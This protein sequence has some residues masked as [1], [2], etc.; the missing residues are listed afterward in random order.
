MKMS[1]L[2]KTTFLIPG[3]LG[4]LAMVALALWLGR[5][6]DKPL[7]LRVPGTD[8]A[9]GSESGSGANAV[10]AGKLI[11]SDGQPANLPGAWP[12]F[13]GPNRDGI[14][15]ET[16]SLARAWQPAEPRELWAIDVGEGYAGAAVLQ[17]ARLS[18]GLRPRQEAG[19]PAL[20][21]AGGRARDLAL[22][23][24]G[25]GEAQ[26]RH[27]AHRAGGHRQAASWRWAPSATSC[28]WIPSRA[29]CAGGWTW[30]GNMARP[31]RPGMPG[32]AR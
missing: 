20:P 11:R 18:H 30:S 25:P 15:P 28:A 8:Q 27:V 19:R 23:L 5:G 29:S 2:A 1:G 13:R 22:R 26:P 12:Q 21:V 3:A 14:S 17:R 24:P 32:S 7:A 16:V 6:S 4:L 10:L 31:C 9:P